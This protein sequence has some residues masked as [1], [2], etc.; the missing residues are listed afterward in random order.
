MRLCEGDL[1]QSDSTSEDRPERTVA[2]MEHRLTAVSRQRLT[3][4]QRV[5]FSSRSA[6]PA[7]VAQ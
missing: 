5:G 3:G 4:I 6:Q 2:G 7:L 1:L